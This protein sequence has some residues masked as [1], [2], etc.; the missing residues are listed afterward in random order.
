MHI[1][2]RPLLATGLEWGG[3]ARHEL[4]RRELERRRVE[5]SRVECGRVERGRIVSRAAA[6][7]CGADVRKR[8]AEPN[9]CGAPGR[10]LADVSP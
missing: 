4:E 9:S 8:L 1:E 2:V 3:G 5:S 6:V 7:R 10:D